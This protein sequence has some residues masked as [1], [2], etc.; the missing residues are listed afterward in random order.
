[1]LKLLVPWAGAGM[2]KPWLILEYFLSPRF[3][4]GA[5]LTLWITVISLFFGILVGLLLALLQESKNRYLKALAIAYL[6]LFRGT[7]ALF[8]IIF[9]FNV[10]PQFGITLSNFLSGVVALAMNEGAYMS[11]IIR[12]GLQAVGRGQRTA[13]RALGMKEWQVMRYVVLPQA[14]RVI[15]PPTGNQFIGM[16]KL[17][18]LVSTVAVEDLLLVANQ[19]ASS[20][21]RYLEALSAAGIYYLIFTTLFMLAQARIEDWASGKRRRR[22]R[23]ATLVERMIGATGAGGRV[24]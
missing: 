5:A 18:A 20:N 7:P 2:D 22:A 4:S 12:S 14:L 23:R 19:A 16:L 1:L 11:E 9:V 8:Q 17:S 10:L 21:F 6:W 3:V 13:A 24:R 15:I